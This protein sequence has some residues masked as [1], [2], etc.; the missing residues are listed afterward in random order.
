MKKDGFTLVEI[1]IVV[2]IIT[3]LAG[4]SI[5][6]LLA[7]K[8]TAN[9]AVAKATLRSL[10][11]AA[12]TY[13]TA[14]SGTYPAA[15]T[16]PGL[17]DFIASAPNYC[18]DVTGTTTAVQGYNYACTLTAGSYTFVASPVTVGTTGTVTY[19]A[20]TGANITPLQ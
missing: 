3:L 13:A 14:H 8:R 9:Q 19:T 2:A 16:A 18:A 7:A 11:T 10:S 6:N 4:I 5:P 15:I 20:S 1:M 17:V 12:E